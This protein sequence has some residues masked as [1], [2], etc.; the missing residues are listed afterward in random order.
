MAKHTTAITD[1]LM[2]GIKAKGTETKDLSKLFS[3]R[4]V[5][6][7]L[8]AGRGRMQVLASDTALGITQE[9]LLILRKR[10]LN[11]VLSFFSTKK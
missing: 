1:E 6:V 3:S 10:I 4:I 11:L 9:K 5:G 7:R 8:I 2:K